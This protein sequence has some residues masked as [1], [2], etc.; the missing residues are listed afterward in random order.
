MSYSFHSSHLICL[1]EQ[2]LQIAAFLTN[3]CARSRQVTIKIGALKEVNTRIG[4]KKLQ[5][6]SQ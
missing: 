2:F 4:R 3:I 1:K 5:V 6:V